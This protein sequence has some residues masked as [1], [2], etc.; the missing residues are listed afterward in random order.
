MLKSRYLTL[1]LIF[2][3][4]YASA[5]KIELID[6]IYFEGRKQ[7]SG[8]YIDTNNKG[9]ICQKIEI[10][11]GKQNG[12]TIIYY[13]NGKI[14]EERYFKEGLRD[15]IWTTW[16]EEGKKIAIAQFF[17]NLKD[18]NWIIWDEKGIMR[19]DMYYKNGE[20]I[21]TWRMWDENGKLIQ[22]KKY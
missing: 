9:E 3:G 5:Q 10:I 6:G 20:K 11:N 2:L 21:A 12:K 18:G 8:I 16:S 14:K 4:L 22:E 1:L 15:S 19:Y 17:N 7:Y 13:Q